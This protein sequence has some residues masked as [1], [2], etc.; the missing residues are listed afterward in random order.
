MDLL[1]HEHGVVEELKDLFLSEGSIQFIAHLLQF[2]VDKVD[3]DLFKGIELKNL[4]TGNVQHTNE[5]DFLHCWVAGQQKRS[6][7]ET[8]LTT[9]DTD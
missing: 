7:L 4:E 2:L 3:T 1:Q 8:Y 5:G 9:F 6:K